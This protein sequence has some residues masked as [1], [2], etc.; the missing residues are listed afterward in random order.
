MSTLI[1]QKLMLILPKNKIKSLMR[2]TLVLYCTF[3][4]FFQ[5][6]LLHQFVFLLMNFQTQKEEEALSSIS[7]Y[8]RIMSLLIFLIRILFCSRDLQ[9]F[10]I[11]L[12]ISIQQLVLLLFTQFV[13]IV[14]FCYCFSLEILV[15]WKVNIITIVCS[16]MI[17]FHQLR[18]N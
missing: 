15:E 6:F 11:C 3:E 14:T 18:Q 7:C 13:V 16:T 12:S 8:K 5:F 9:F 17:R 4:F 10:V 1:L 2:L